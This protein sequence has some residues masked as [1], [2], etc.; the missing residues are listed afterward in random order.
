[1]KDALGDR[2]KS[3]YENRTRIL[4]PRRTYSVCRLDGKSFHSYCRGLDRPFDQG[5]MD[6]MDATAIALCEEIQGAAFAFVQSDEISVL[7]TDFAKDDTEAWFDGNIQK[8]VSV[9]ASLAAAHFNILRFGTEKKHSFPV[10]DSRV[11]TIPDPVEVENYFVWRQQDATRNSVLMAAQAKFSHNQLL[12]KSSTEMQEMLFQEHGINWSDYP[13]GFKRG[14][15][16]K[17]EVSSAVLTYTDRRSGETVTLPAP[18]MRSSWVS[19][20]PPVFTQDRAW[21]Q[22]LIPR[23][24]EGG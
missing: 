18:V 13:V 8:I 5:L 15:V 16:I 6:D 19:V 1:M 10:F 22:A 17:E 24:H 11:F 20:E 9:A 21:L 2:M 7:M 12:G 23:H 14:R 4:L 3:S